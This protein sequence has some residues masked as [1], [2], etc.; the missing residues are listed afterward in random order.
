MSNDQ[1]FIIEVD[2]EAAGI[3]VG[4]RRGFHFFAAH[5]RYSALEARVFRSAVEAER[6]AR[7]IRWPRSIPR[8]ERRMRAGRF[9]A[10]SAA[11][12]AAF[13]SRTGGDGRRT[14]RP[15]LMTMSE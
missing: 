6:A 7:S 10:L 13:R 11:F 1:S 15:E 3:I 8:R 4:D 14:S 12:R 9:E 2:D 5:H